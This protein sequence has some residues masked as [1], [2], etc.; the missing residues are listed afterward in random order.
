M[1]SPADT[2]SRRQSQSSDDLVQVG[3]DEVRAGG[4]VER[5]PGGEAFAHEPLVDGTTQHLAVVMRAR[6]ARQKPE[7]VAHPGE[8]RP[9]RVGHAGFE[10]ADHPRAP[11]AEEDAALPGLAEDRVE[12]MRAPDGEE[13]RGVAAADE[14]DVVRERELPESG[15]RPRIEGQRRQLEAAEPGSESYCGLAVVSKSTRDPRASPSR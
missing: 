11:A 2:S 4:V 1:R 5:D 14:D 13:I 12:P 6:A 8:P 15:R 3:A 9:E 7:A 10:P